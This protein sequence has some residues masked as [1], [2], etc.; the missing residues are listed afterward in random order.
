MENWSE[1]K[2]VPIY[3]FIHS[4]NIYVWEQK[5]KKEE[6]ANSK[7]PQILIV[8]PGALET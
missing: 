7:T 4:I 3:S 1:N 5:K 2:K 8:L 6:F